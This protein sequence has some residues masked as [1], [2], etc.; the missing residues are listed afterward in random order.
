MS[1]TVKR[2]KRHSKPRSL[3]H[4]RLQNRNTMLLVTNTSVENVPTCVNVVHASDMV[5]SKF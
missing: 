2:E 4:Q 3:P 1:T 5:I